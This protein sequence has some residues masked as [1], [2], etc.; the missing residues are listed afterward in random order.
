[1]RCRHLTTGENYG[2]AI[3]RRTG[4]KTAEH[5]RRMR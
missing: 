2:F 3:E 1:V 5:S 4:L